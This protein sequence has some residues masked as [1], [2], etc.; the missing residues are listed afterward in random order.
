MLLQA[1]LGAGEPAPC[2]TPRIATEGIKKSKMLTTLQGKAPKTQKKTKKNLTFVGV[3]VKRGV[4]T[5]PYRPKTW[6]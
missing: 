1:L 3:H 6:C 2:S 5:S 4:K